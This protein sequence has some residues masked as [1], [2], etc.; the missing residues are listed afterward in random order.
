MADDDSPVEITF[1]MEEAVLRIPT[2]VNGQPGKVWS[3]PLAD[4]LTIPED[5]ADWW[6]NG[7]AKDDRRDG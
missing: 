6:K 1:H 4:V 3:I 5:P 2:S 7:E